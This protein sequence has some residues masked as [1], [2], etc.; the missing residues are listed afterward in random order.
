MAKKKKKKNRVIIEHPT[1]FVHEGV[2]KVYEEGSMLELHMQLKPEEWT[3]IVQ[4]TIKYYHFL[5]CIKTVACPILKEPWDEMDDYYRIQL[6]L[7]I[8][9][10]RNIDA[11]LVA[12]VNTEE[13][14]KAYTAKMTTNA[15]EVMDLVKSVKTQQLDQAAE[16]RKT[17]IRDI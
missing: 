16:E 13:L 6:E 3:E 5:E 8:S 2:I 15:T 11:L 14:V 7:A 4:E 17:K 12:S 1:M 9:R 10:M